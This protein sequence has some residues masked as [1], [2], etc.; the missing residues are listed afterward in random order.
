MD[1]AP[2]KYCPSCRGEFV[3]ELST[4]PDCEVPLVGE[5]PEVETSDDDLVEVFRTGDATLLPVIV[6]LL[7]ASGV[8]CIVQGA[9][10]AG[11]LF[12][13]GAAGGKSLAALILVPEGRAEEAKALLVASPDVPT[14][15]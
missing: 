11:G 13:L 12:P 5:L 14:D 1:G 15:E 10:A 4:C 8:P 2:P 3:A 6:S 9:E 7:D